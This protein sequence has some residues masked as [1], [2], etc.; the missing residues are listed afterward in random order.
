VRVYRRF[1][2]FLLSI[3]E[4]QFTLK[5]R[6]SFTRTAPPDRTRPTGALIV[7]G[8]GSPT[9]APTSKGR[10]MKGEP[11]ILISAVVRR[12]LHDQLER[13]ADAQDR[14]IASIIRLAITDY[15]ARQGGAR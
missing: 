10:F 14:S 4:I 6:R 1:R 2:L 7:Y 8:D 3:S 5:F 9:I 15:I 12:T 11:E 13:L